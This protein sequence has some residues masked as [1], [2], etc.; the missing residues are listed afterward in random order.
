M[1]KIVMKYF[2]KIII[3]FVLVFGALFAY[4]VLT[5]E[6]RSK[7]VVIKEGAYECVKI[8]DT[9]GSGTCFKNE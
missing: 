4:S 6:P 5:A 9:F 8:R 7:L 1:S 3:V 2:D